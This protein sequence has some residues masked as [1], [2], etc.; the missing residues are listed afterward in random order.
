MGMYVHNWLPRYVASKLV[1]VCMYQA[2][3]GWTP[4]TVAM[5]YTTPPVDAYICREVSRRYLS[6]R[7]GLCVT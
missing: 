3:V 4:Q 2:P 5:I 1:Y 7:W 6:S